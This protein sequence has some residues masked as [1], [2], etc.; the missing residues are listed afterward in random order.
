MVVQVQVLAGLSIEIWLWVLFLTTVD[1]LY[2][3]F[4]EVGFSSERSSPFTQFLFR[5]DPLQLKPDYSIAQNNYSWS[6]QLDAFWLDQPGN[7]VCTA[8]YVRVFYQDYSSRYRVFHSGLRR[9][10]W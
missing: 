2:G 8:V 10:L 6:K 3:F 4:L 1:S 7:W 9:W 5:M